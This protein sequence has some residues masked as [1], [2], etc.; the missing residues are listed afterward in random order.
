MPAESDWR[1]YTPCTWFMW[2]S[3][4]DYEAI[5]VMTFIEFLDRIDASP[6]TLYS[7]ILKNWIQLFLGL[8][9]GGIYA[10]TPHGG[11]ESKSEALSA[12]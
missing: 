12:R 6:P 5:V 3:Y 7:I 9:F 2:S 1:Q 4:R 10:R 11:T 8:W